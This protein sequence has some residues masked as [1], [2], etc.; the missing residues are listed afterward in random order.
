VAAR[1]A[2]L[3]ER[4]LRRGLGHKL[5]YDP[6]IATLALCEALHLAR[7][8]AA[9]QRAER[10]RLPLAARDPY[11]AWRDDAR[12]SGDNDRSVA[13]WMVLALKSAE[14]C[15][16]TLDREAYVGALN[17]FDEVTDPANGRI[18]YDSLGSM[19]SRVADV[20]DSFPPEKGEAM[21]AVGRMCRFFLGR[22]TSASR[23]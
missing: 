20:K 2:G 17:W 4:A 1:A 3:R 10:D 14:D 22:S 9:S 6:A 15:G 18:G 16:L 8:D 13:V 11:G 21:T 12:T 23:S 5:L 19:S 7:P